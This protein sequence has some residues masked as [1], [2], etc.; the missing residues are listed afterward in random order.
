MKLYVRSC[1]YELVKSSWNNEK[2]EEKENVTKLL[3]FASCEQ[4]NWRSAL[5]GYSFKGQWRII[6]WCKTS[7]KMISIL[8]A[9]YLPRVCIDICTFKFWIQTEPSIHSCLTD[10][11]PPGVVKYLCEGGECDYSSP[12]PS[13]P[14]DGHLGWLSRWSSTRWSWSG[15]TRGPVFF[16]AFHNDAAK[17]ATR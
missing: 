14:A 2:S 11:L 1:K 4:F 5:K 17:L 3:S 15:S 7:I 6:H 8:L 13:F 10:E 16:G 12:A 9:V